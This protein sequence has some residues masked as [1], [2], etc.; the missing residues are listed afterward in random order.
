MSAFTAGVLVS[1]GVYLAIG[2]FVGRRVRSV[3]DYYV[4]NRRAPT[5]LV[6]GS[7]VASFLS[8]VAFMGEVGLA[9]EGYPIVLLILAVLNASGYVIGVLLFGRYL[10]R[11]RTLT[12]PEYFR[13][14]FDSRRLQAAAGITVILG[15]G[16]YLVAVTQGVSLLLSDIAGIS[17]GAALLIVWVTY[18]LFTFIAGSPGVLVT[19][20]VMFGVFM[21]A[22]VAAMTWLTIDAGG[23]AS[24][25]ESLTAMQ[26]KPDLLAAHGLTGEAASLGPPGEAI[27]WAVI[28]GVVWATV[29]A[30]SPWQTSRYLMARDE[31]TSLRSGFLAMASLIVLYVFLA[32]GGAAI[33]VFR[34]NVD[35]TE[36]AFVW[37]AQNVVP[38]ALGVVAIA[39]IM[40]AG[41]SSSTTFLSLI[42]FS[43]SRDIAPALSARRRAEFDED[44]R[45]A[46]RFSRLVMLAVGLVV[47]AVTWEAPPAVLTI[48]YFAATL[49]AGSWGPVAI[50]SVHH[51]GMTERGALWG[52]VT[53]FT[54]VFVLQAFVEFGDLELPI[55]AHPV[56]IGVV[57][58]VAA[59]WL[60]NRGQEV[61][62]AQREY[63]A[64]LV[65]IPEPAL[66]PARARATGRFAFV[67]GAA[68]VGTGLLLT[69]TYLVPYLDAT[70]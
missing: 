8:T 59:M 32:L 68:A 54:V 70:G 37:A 53:G 17:F 51:R 56:I 30:V 43:A 40:A 29:V 36:L 38:T 69:L 14:R 27:A 62:A 34:G 3:A 52:L 6:T 24:V 39:G 50:G 13:L 12:V 47:L 45:A 9:Y 64:S 22:G 31:H 28:L 10:Q 44:D 18:T 23:P 60:G 46:L 61:T 67:L 42:G 49:F 35:P 33:N 58:N 55:W 66:Q 1:F 26:E 21:L 4:A 57:A 16:V 11:A 2:T 65:R 5:L 7:L 15:V 41:L 63:R 48:G 20:T 19:D 25:V